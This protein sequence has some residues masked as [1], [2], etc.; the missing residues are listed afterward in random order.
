MTQKPPNEKRVANFQKGM[1]TNLDQI[2]QAHKT[3]EFLKT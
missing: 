2:E 1:E 3:T